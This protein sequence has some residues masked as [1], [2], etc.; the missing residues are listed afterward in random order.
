MDMRALKA[1]EIAAR[2]RLTYSDGAWSV[3]SQSGGSPYRVVLSTANPTCTCDDFTLRGPPCKHILAAQLV[4]Q[5]DHGGQAP[6]LDVDSPPKKKTYAQVW[7]AYNLAQTTEKH[8]FRVLLADLCRGL[9]QPVRAKPG[10]PRTLLAD[11]VFAV[12]FKTYCG[13]SSRRFSCDLQDAHARGYVTKPIHYN[14]INSYLENAEL[15]PVLHALIVRSSLPLRALETCFAVDSS[16]FSVSRFVRWYD[17]KHGVS[18][19][20]HDWVKVHLMCGVRTNIVTAVK[21]LDRDAADGPQLPPLLK[22]TR[23]Y[24]EVKEVTADKAYSSVEN[25]EAVFEAAGF[26]YIAFKANTTGAAGGL[27]QKLYCYFELFREDFLTHYHQRSNVESTFSMVK[28]KFGGH[29]RSR[30]D[31]AMKN[32]ALCKVLCHNICCVIGAQCEL[33]IAARFWDDEE[34]PIGPQAGCI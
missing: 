22:T 12:A 7:P 24:F 21:I 3:P 23:Q 11:A 2:V 8:R 20:G 27:W 32:E 1:L 34:N 9:T 33:G 15:T 6:T 26:P 14:S 17:E 31:V 29:V 28:A 13:L 19:S 4:Q 18:R 10:R 30:T 25:V 5:R 16:G